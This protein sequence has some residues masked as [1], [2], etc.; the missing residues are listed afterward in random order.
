M[1]AILAKAVDQFP[2]IVLA[3]L[4]GLLFNRGML[5]P[6]GTVTLLTSA[7]AREREDKIKAEAKAE[8]WEDRAF[9]LAKSNGRVVDAVEKVATAAE[10]VVATRPGV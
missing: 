4:V 8:R 3:I 1:E 5:V 2:A 7:L 6:P 10:V 9:E